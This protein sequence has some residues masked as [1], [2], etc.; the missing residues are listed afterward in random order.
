MAIDFWFGIG[1]TY[2]YLTVMRLDAV[3]AE[4]GIDF[5]WRPINIRRMM[6]SMNNIPYADKPAKLAYM[7]R[8]LARRAEGYGIE[9]KL[10]PPYTIKDLPRANRIA[11]LGMREGWGKDYVKESYRLWFTEGLDAGDE[12]NFRQSLRAARQDPAEALARADSPEAED[13]L[14]RETDAALALGLFGAPSFTV[15]D[16]P[17]WGDDRLD[18]AIAW[19]RRTDPS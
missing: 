18:D 13:A 5:R 6:L 11:A 1:S 10:P 12:P 14:E 19:H 9:A 3:S 15:G 2:S 4:T 7:W 16:E 17:F 8:D